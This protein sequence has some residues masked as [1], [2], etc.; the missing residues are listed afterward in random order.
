MDDDLYTAIDL[1]TE[2]LEKQIR[3][4]KERYNSLKQKQAK[5]Y[6]D[7]F[8]DFEAADDILPE[9]VKRKSLRLSKPMDINEAILEME[10]VN[11]DFF[12][13][14]DSETKNTC[15]LYKRRDGNYGLI[16]VE[17]SAN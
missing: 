4:N 14:K 17:K 1:I 16:E 8:R 5:E 7:I 10:F 6:N 15:V 9:L 13:Y 2:K 3:R 11:H 12:I